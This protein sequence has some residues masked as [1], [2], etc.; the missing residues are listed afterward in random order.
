MI[1]II[2]WLLIWFAM[3]TALAP[4]F[5]GFLRAGRGR[6]HH[7]DTDADSA[8]LPGLSPVETTQPPR[9]RSYVGGLA[10]QRYLR[11]KTPQPRYSRW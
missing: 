3:S 6:E 9:G 2:D 7:A 8:R 4:L 11:T 5:G 1:H 10:D